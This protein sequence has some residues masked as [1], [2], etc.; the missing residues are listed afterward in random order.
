MFAELSGVFVQFLKLS[1]F[2]NSRQTFIKG[3]V[4]SFSFHFPV[5]DNEGGS[6]VSGEFAILF[7]ICGSSWNRAKDRVSV[8]RGW[9]YSRLHEASSACL[10][11]A[12]PFRP[13]SLPGS[14]R[15]R[16]PPWTAKTGGVLEITASRFSS[17]R[18]ARLMGAAFS[19]GEPSSC[20]VS[21][22]SFIFPTSFNLEHRCLPSCRYFSAQPTMYNPRFSVSF[23][24]LFRFFFFFLF[25]FCRLRVF[26]ACWGRSQWQ[27]ESDKFHFE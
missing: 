18:A 19:P 13:F 11:L 4:V 27:I 25:L 14:T 1:Q 10:T 6:R 22:S 23:A 9:D 20:H 7:R 17:W 16:E 15:D 5:R 24:F 2:T 21:S 12:A 26:N 3:S 8:Q